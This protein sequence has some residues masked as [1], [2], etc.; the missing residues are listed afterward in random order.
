MLKQIFTWILDQLRG[1]ALV[2]GDLLLK[3]DHCPISG[4]WKDREL[5]MFQG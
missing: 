2:D 1:G 3:D 4:N 5:D